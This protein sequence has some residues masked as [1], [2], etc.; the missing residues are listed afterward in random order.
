MTS[1]VM[2]IKAE[3]LWDVIPCNL[4]EVRTYRIPRGHI[5][6]ECNLDN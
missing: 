1:T 5:P 2:S 3:V 6:A 4:A